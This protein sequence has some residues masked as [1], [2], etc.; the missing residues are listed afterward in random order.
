MFIPCRT[1]LNLSFTFPGRLSGLERYCCLVYTRWLIFISSWLMVWSISNMSSGASS[2]LS[3]RLRLICSLSSFLISY[4]MKVVQFLIVVFLLLN[5][6]IFQYLTCF[7]SN[8]SLIHIFCWIRTFYR[9]D[10]W[11]MDAPIGYVWYISICLFEN[12]SRLRNNYFFK[13]FDGPLGIDESIPY[14]NKIKIVFK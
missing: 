1:S 12:R 6:S 9:I 2:N 13:I 4:I 11:L 8:I 3:A 5:F 10:N 7:A 14:N